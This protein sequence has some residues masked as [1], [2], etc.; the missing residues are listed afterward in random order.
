MPAER[1]RALRSIDTSTLA[2]RGGFKT[3]TASLYRP[4]TA[5]RKSKLFIVAIRFCYYCSEFELRMCRRLRQT[6]GEEDH[7]DDGESRKCE[8]WH[9]FQTQVNSGWSGSSRRAVFAE[10]ALV[11]LYLTRAAIL[12]EPGPS[13]DSGARRRTWGPK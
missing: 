4:T 7:P 5:A 1:S 12:P 9:L 13:R 6:S 11:A 8:P 3:E 10:V 2:L